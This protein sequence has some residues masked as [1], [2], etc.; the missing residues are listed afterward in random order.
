[1]PPILELAGRLGRRK[2]ALAH[3]RILNALPQLPHVSL[4]PRWATCQGR[5]G[6]VAPARLVRW[7]PDAP[8]AVAGYTER[9]RRPGAVCHSDGRSAPRYM[10]SIALGAYVVMLS[11]I[12]LASLEF[13]LSSSGLSPRLRRAIQSYTPS[14]MPVVR[15]L[16]DDPGIGGVV[17][18]GTPTMETALVCSIHR[19][20]V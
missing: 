3:K 9:C 15:H 18:T 19:C 13:F 11:G 6:L 17:A 20:C 1:M 5:R 2:G 10:R 7:I 12:Y 14:P 8:A 4:M 16:G